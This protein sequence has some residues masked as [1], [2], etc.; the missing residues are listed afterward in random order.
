MRIYRII[1]IG[2]ENPAEFSVAEQLKIY[3]LLLDYVAIEIVYFSLLPLF[4]QRAVYNSI[5]Q[6][7]N[8]QMRSRVPEFRKKFLRESFLQIADSFRAAGS[9]FAADRALDHFEMMNAP[10]G[11]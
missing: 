6:L 4:D 11:N 8:S 7:F 3:L 5:R 10:L 9:H 1:D 2:T